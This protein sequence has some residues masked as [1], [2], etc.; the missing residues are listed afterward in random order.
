MDSAILHFCDTCGTTWDREHPADVICSICAFPASHTLINMIV[1][2]LEEGDESNIDHI[3]H[4]WQ[5][6][7][8]RYMWREVIQMGNKAELVFIPLPPNVIVAPIFHVLQTDTKVKYLD[9]FTGDILL[10]VVRSS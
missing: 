6:E 7:C 5:D 2:F 8:G 9:P 4:V 1:E 10:D 3:S